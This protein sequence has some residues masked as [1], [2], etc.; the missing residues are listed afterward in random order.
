M[1]DLGNALKTIGEFS[2]WPNPRQ[3]ISDIERKLENK[4]ITQLKSLLNDEDI[5][6]RTIR[7]ALEVK[8]LAGQIN[9]FI[10]AVG[11]LISLPHILK[12]DERI[13]YLSLGAGNT[14]RKFD[15]E[16]NKRVAEFTFIQ[17]RG[18]SESIRQNGVFVDLFNLVECETIKKRCLYV[19]DKKYP[20]Q[21]FNKRRK[22]RSVLSKNL[23]ISE[24]FFD[25]Y[26]D[27]Y[28]VVAQY[29]NDVKHLVEIIDLKDV[30]PVFSG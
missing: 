23:A 1:A 11:I 21:F 7:A 8:Q 3:R 4:D 14:G 5:G 29:Y 24:R 19:V 2:M 6:D 27:K 16:T 13:L 30:V 18:G 28:Q 22:I 25:K 15:L 26:G 10:H 12:P 17:W 9:V 20:I